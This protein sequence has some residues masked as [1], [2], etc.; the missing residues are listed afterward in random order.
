M[1]RILFERGEIVDGRAEFSDG[2]AEHVL[3]VLHGE[4]GQV[5][6]TGELDGLAGTSVITEGVFDNRFRYVDELV[7][8]NDVVLI[9]QSLS[10]A[11][12]YA[13]GG[14]AKTAMT[15]QGRANA[16]CF[17]PG[18]LLTGKDALSVQK[19]LLGKITLPELPE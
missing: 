14:S 4:V 13:V 12:L 2:R 19:Y 11:D 18:S 16:D 10:N 15:E 8:M 9:M 5:L 3:N 7:K 1:N 17:D 6:K